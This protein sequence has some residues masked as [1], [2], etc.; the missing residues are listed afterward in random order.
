MVNKLRTTWEKIRCWK[1][2]IWLKISC[3]KKAQIGFLLE[4]AKKGKKYKNGHNWWKGENWLESAVERGEK[5][6]IVENQLTEK[7]KIGW[8]TA[9]EFEKA[10]NG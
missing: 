10:K 1:G 5:V 3:F 2:G 8:K 9:V 6:K 7:A 4:K